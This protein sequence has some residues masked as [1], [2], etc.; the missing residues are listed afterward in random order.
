MEITFLCDLDLKDCATLSNN[1]VGSVKICNCLT[2][3]SQMM[4]E[5]LFSRCHAGQ[6]CHGP[7]VSFNSCVAILMG[8]GQAINAE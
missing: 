1:V 2:S 4:I 3:V 6:T 7:F 5:P 8:V